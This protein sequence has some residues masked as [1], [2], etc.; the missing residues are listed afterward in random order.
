MSVVA[1][2]VLMSAADAVVMDQDMIWENATVLETLKI[3]TVSA[4]AV[5]L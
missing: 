3:V 1:Q 4:V 2:T 5:L